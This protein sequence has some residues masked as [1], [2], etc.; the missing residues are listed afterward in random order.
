[1]SSGGGQTPPNR[2]NSQQLSQSMS[3]FENRSGQGGQGQQQ[4]G[5]APTGQ[6]LSTGNAPGGGG[7][8]G[9][10]L[11]N[12]RLKTV[13]DTQSNSNPATVNDRTL[14]DILGSGLTPNQS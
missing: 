9:D 11:A 14:R 13:N 1:M 2:T 3:L 10:S 8:P 12:D 7:N 6:L 4:P 5:G